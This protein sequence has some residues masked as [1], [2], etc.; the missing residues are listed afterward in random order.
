MS[1]IPP[2]APAALPVP[3]WTHR[4][5]AWIE[6]LPGPTWL[7]LLAIG[8]VNTVA[9]HQLPWSKGTVAVGVID[10]AS[11]VWGF[12]LTALLWIARD[13]ERVAARTFD[14]AR[15]AL[16]LPPDA[17]DRLR[18]DLI[19]VPAR[20]ALVVISVAALANAGSILSDPVQY[21]IGVPLPV[22]I[23]VAVIQF[24]MISLLFEILYRLVRQARLIRRTLDQ[25][26]T[27]DVFRPGAL[28]GFATLA[29]RPGILICLIVAATL[30]ATPPSSLVSVEAFVVGVAPFVVVA[31]LIAVGSFVAPLAG[32][33]DRLEAQKAQLQDDLELRLQTT[34]ATLNREVDAGDL[35]RADGLNKTLASLVLQRDILAKLPT[36]PWSTATLR[37]FGSAILLPL[38]IFLAQQA[39]TRL[40]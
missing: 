2:T 17:A 23:V 30:P 16:T 40:F 10:P 1:L 7:A 38:G 8:I 31:P 19:V 4:V 25:G 3:S 14:A 13:L 6:G 36:W 34:L 24:V 35:A 26:M 27:V 28:H 20:T 32:A 37:A 33:H 22:T 21:S 39:L 11:V 5:V 12:L 15:P 29:A 18:N 9:M